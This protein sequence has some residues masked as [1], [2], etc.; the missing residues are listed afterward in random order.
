MLFRSGSIRDDI[1]ELLPS[2]V[3][4]VSPS[5]VPPDL[6]I[7]VDVCVFPLEEKRE[8]LRAVWR[9]LPSSA[10]LLSCSLCST[11]TEIASW[12]ERPEKVAGFGYVGPLADTGLVEIA[13]G[14]KSDA[15]S[16]REA[17]S[18]F[19]LLGKETELVQDS[20]GLVLPRILSLIINE[21]VW[22]LSE[23]LA[24]REGIDL[25]MKLGTHYPYGP[26]EWGDR[27]GLDLVEQ[28]LDAIGRE[29]NEDRYRPAPLLKKM[30]LAGW[31][32]Q[33]TRRGFYE[34]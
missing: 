2:D 34:Y 33:R 6:S 25:A 11:V 9:S 22:A 29:Q 17:E 21:A 27:I 13:A 3:K 28:I 19:K 26:L 30:V 4:R 12:N 5:D 7:A 16:V 8:R 23:G 18:F 1:E 10:T 14:L 20:A 32:G 15:G 24:T 31:L